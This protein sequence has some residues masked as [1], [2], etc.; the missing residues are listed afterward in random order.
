MMS[1][2]VKGKC[3]RTFTLIFLLFSLLF[4]STS[5]ALATLSFDEFYG[6]QGVLGFEFSEKVK[7]LAGQ[8]VRVK[9]FM[10]PP[11]KAESNFFVLT[12]VPLSICPFCDS[13][14]DWPAD[15]LVIYL[16]DKQTFVQ[17]NGTIEVEGILEYGS[18][19]DPQTGFVSLLRL[20][21][22]KIVD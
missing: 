4:S 16:D 2:V 21:H 11:L 6:T 5:Q 14:A 9:G 1:I 8:K 10:A 17:L 15:I 19:T 22:A 7:K 20:T 18:W 13:D 3:G 12:R